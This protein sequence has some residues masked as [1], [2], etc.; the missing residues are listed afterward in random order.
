[1]SKTEELNVALGLLKSTKMTLFDLQNQLANERSSRI[2]D[3][4]EESRLKQVGMWKISRRS[5]T[6]R[7]KIHLQE[8]KNLQEEVRSKSLE[9]DKSACIISL[10]QT[11]LSAMEEASRSYN[12]TL[13]E[14]RNVQI[15]DRDVLINNMKRLAEGNRTTIEDLEARCSQLNEEIDQLKSNASSLSLASI[16]VCR[17]CYQ[18]GVFGLWRLANMPFS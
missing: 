18:G 7:Q 16:E 4:D 1:M 9:I 15:K 12:E 11:D 13:A 5:F 3:S 14:L 10:L 8:L 17:G 2:R 6:K